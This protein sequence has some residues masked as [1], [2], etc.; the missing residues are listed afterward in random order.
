MN[1]QRKLI[2]AAAIAGVIGTFMPWVSVSAGAFGYSVSRSQNGFHGFGILFFL[3]VIAVAVLALL[4]DRKYHIQKNRRLPVMIAG[5][6][7]LVCVLIT[8]MDIKDSM[9]EFALARASVGLGL[10]LS[11]VA[12]AAIVAIPNLIKN[13]EDSLS[14]DLSSLSNKVEEIQN[15]IKKPSIPVV[16]TSSRIDELERLIALRENGRITEQ[17]YQEL[18]SK[19]I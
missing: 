18:K 12:S 14:S 16:K 5:V 15:E 6:I 2:L 7:A 10:I 13:P 9:G 11:F 1:K 17:E 19:I 3:I 4:G 8:Y